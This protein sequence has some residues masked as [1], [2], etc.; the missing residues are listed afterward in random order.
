[1]TA[2]QEE[3]DW[4]VYG[5]YGLLSADEWTRLTTVPGAELPPLPPGERAFEIVLARKVADGTASSSWFQRLSWFEN[6][7]VTPV[8]DVPNHWPTTYRDVVQA[9]VDAIEPGH[10]IALV[11]RPEYKRR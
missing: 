5:A 1:M 8:T 9:R 11:E 10:T 4:D 6:Q 3:L 2:L 7:G